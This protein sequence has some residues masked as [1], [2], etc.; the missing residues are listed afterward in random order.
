MRCGTTSDEV[1]A[2]SGPTKRA[3]L[4]GSVSRL[5]QIRHPAVGMLDH[6]LAQAGQEGDCGEGER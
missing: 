1:P 3:W 5:P 2:H 6:R 4:A